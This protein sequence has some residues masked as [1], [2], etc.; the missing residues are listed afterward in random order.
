MN[1]QAGDFKFLV[2]HSKS[3]RSVIILVSQNLDGGCWFSETDGAG[4]AGYL[5]SGNPG[6]HEAGCQDW[7]IT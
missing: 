7:D 2:N 1:W 4:T 6:L 3:K 5:I